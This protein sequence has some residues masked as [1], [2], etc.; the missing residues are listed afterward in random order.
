[1]S[2]E[3]ELGWLSR[4]TEKTVTEWQYA[5]DQEEKYIG[6]R[7]HAKGGYQSVRS[8]FLIPQQLYFSTNIF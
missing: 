6:R 5:V 1:M 7:V 8:A 4:E 2:R 3:G